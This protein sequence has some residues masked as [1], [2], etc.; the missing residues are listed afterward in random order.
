MEPRYAMSA[1]CTAALAVA[2]A[3]CTS[4]SAGRTANAGSCGPLAPPV[5]GSIV[6]DSA[7]GGVCCGPGA[8]VSP[9]DTTF[10]NTAAGRSD[11][12]P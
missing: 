6:E 2:L 9:G 11:P 12:A 7:A 5:D 1:A 8:T 10:T 3:A 4:P